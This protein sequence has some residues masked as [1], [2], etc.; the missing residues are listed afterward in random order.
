MSDKAFS[1]RM[2]SELHTLSNIVAKHLNVSKNEVICGLLEEWTVKKVH[3]I[4]QKPY[5]GNVD[6]LEDALS[7][8]LQ[9]RQKEREEEIKLDEFIGTFRHSL[10]RIKE[11]QRIEIENNGKKITDTLGKYCSYLSSD[12]YA[13]QNAYDTSKH[14]KKFL[15]DDD[16][17]ALL[18]TWK[19]NWEN[20]WDNKRQAEYVSN[21]LTQ[22]AFN[23]EDGHL[24][25]VISH[26]DDRQTDPERYSTYISFLMFHCRDIF[27]SDPITAPYCLNFKVQ[28]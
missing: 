23:F 14:L 15:S 5:S 20:S 12:K 28:A 11:E 16:T 27:L 18:D 3:E 1:L 25:T 6:D 7:G 4:I 2:S 17:L 9:L 26:V 19:Q 21:K 8:L 22:M 24:G 13:I 10:N